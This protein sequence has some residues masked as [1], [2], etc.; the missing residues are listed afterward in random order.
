MEFFRDLWAYM[1][2]RKRWWLTPI[3]LA[4]VLLGLLFVAST[5]SPLTPLIY[6]VF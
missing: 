2:E 3:I 1:R 5:S 4:L 6:T